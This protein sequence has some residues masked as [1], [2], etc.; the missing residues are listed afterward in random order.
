M[1]QN[2][3]ITQKEQSLPEK[4]ILSTTTD[5]K[6]TILTASDDFVKISGFSRAELIGQPHNIVRHPDT[7]S[8]V[9]ADMWYTLKKGQTWSAMVKNRAKNGD[10]YWVLANVTPMEENGQIV[11]YVSVRTPATRA[12]IQ[13]AE[14]LYQAIHT[15]KWQ[16]Q[17]A[18]IRRRLAMKWDWLRIRAKLKTVLMIYAAAIMLI[19]TGLLATTLYLNDI[20]PIEQQE[21]TREAKATQTLLDNHIHNKVV[22][23]MDLAASVSGFNEVSQTLN[24]TLPKSLLKAELADIR[25]HYARITDYQNIR[26]QVYRDDAS[27]FMNSWSNPPA[28]APQNPLLQAMQQSG[29]VTGGLTVDTHDMGLGVTGYAPVFADERLVGAVAVSSGLASVVG[30]LKQQGIDWVMLLN[31]D[32]FSAGLPTS[33]KNN[34]A[35]SETRILASNGWF[36]ANSVEAFQ[37][38]FNAPQ[39]ASEA[40]AFIQDNRLYIS[41]P[42]YNADGQLIGRHLLMRAADP[43]L[44]KVAAA[45]QQALLTIVELLLLI[46]FIVGTLIWL[47]KQRA[48]KPLMQLSETMRKMRETGR[49]NER[50]N[51]INNGDEINDIVN[52]YNSFVGNVQQS[53]TNINDVMASLAKGHLDVA[54]TGHFKGDF[55]IMQNAINTSVS[56]IRNIMSELTRVVNGMSRGQFDLAVNSEVDGDFKRLLDDLLA[57]MTTIESTIQAIV[58]VMDKMK[59]GKFRH[60]VDIEAHG[61]FKHLKDGVND[62]M[63]ALENAI[64]DLTRIVVAQSN[65]DL[66]HKITT[67]YHGEL[68]ILKEAVNN[69]ADKLVDV[70][71]NAIEASQIVSTAAQE[72]SQGSAN[73]SERVQEQASALE[74]TSATMQQMNAAVQNNSEIAQNT[75][76]ITLEVQAKANSGSEVMQQTLEAMTQIQG[77]SHKIAEIIGLIDGIAFQTNLLALNAAVEAARA[78]EH[79]RGFAVVA[80]EVRALAQKS[81]DAAKDIRQLID[82]SVGRIDK[83]TELATETGE[84]L[85]GITGSIDQVAEMINQIAQASMQQSEGIQQVHHAIGQIDGITQQNAALVEETSAASESLS[86]Q[87]DHLQRDMAFFQTEAAQ[88]PGLR[89]VTSAQS[90]LE[91][92]K[93]DS[94]STTTE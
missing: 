34:Q 25:Q 54:V 82:E 73:L 19:G 40:V 70:V 27:P 58:N 49:F 36:D 52:H 78:G 43:I 77:S 11:G 91:P 8:Q 86:E 66:T 24:G 62:S 55:E 10:H 61:H 67:D 21:L 41:L 79:G 6:G 76:K 37:S 29:K 56:N 68:R 13:E 75:A 92:P 17:C 2:L 63:D 5:L 9:F 93:T 80:G 38:V 47:M 20:A 50:V 45:E 65:G 15:G 32:T 4:A 74:Q 16:L 64:K 26:V 46:V 89:R 53:F 94:L 14:H 30:E 51:L 84:V 1:R 69:T 72:V 42:A 28:K 48:I 60:R 83:G 71:A 90:Q 3:P 31:R 44:N 18:V 7:P 88:T 85:K 22:S 12:Q 39:E 81:A 33:L 23:V 87:A 35:F 57:T 59:N